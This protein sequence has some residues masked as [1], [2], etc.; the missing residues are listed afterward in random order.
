MSQYNLAGRGGKEQE[1]M[2]FATNELGLEL[3]RK[4]CKLYDF[5][6]QNGN[7]IELKK[8]QD[9]QWLNLYSYVELTEDDKNIKMHFAVISKEGAI[10]NV[11]EVPL[12]V[13]IDI[14]WSK[15]KFKDAH[16]WVVKHGTKDQLKTSVQV[17]KFVKENYKVVKKIY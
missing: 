4:S 17:R 11:Y 7:K 3:E 6:D 10:E 14:V 13:L 15:E 16:A 8:Q 12:G 5:V 9:L 1:Y 2:K